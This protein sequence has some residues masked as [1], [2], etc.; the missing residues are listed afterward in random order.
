M[1]NKKQEDN[2]SNTARA[3]LADALK[4]TSRLGDAARKKTLQYAIHMLQT[5]VNK[6]V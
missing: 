3:I 2:A 6:I 4:K 5:E 1:L